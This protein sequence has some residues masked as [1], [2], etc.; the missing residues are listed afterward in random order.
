MAPEQQPAQEPAPEKK[1]RSKPRKEL[2]VVERPADFPGIETLVFAEASSLN[3]HPDNWKTHTDRQVNALDAEFDTV[4]WA[5]AYLYNRATGNMLDGH[6]RNR[7]KEVKRR[8]VVPVL[9][10][11]WTPEQEEQILLHLD[12]IGGMFETEGAKYRALMAKHRKT[13]EETVNQ[14]QEQ[15]RAAINDLNDALDTHT[16]SIDYGAPPSFLPSADLYAN[17]PAYGDEDK[18]DV[19]DLDSTSPYV[20]DSTFDLK[21]FEEIPFDAFGRGGLDIPA[22][23]PDMIA[24]PPEKLQTWVGPETPDADAYFYVYGCAAIEKVRSNRLIVAYY[25]YDHKFESVWN[26]PRKFTARMLNYQVHSVITP[27]YSC[28]NGIHKAYDIWQTFRSR[29]LGR[30]WQSVGLKVIPDL[31]V[32]NIEHDDVF[33]WRMGGL[34]VGLNCVATQM[35]QKGETDPEAYYAQKK[36]LLLKALRHLQPKSLILYHGPDLPPTFLRGIPESTRVIQVRSWMWARG[37]IL[38]GKEYLT[39]DK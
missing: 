1:P 5:G 8:G 7:T 39:D 37:E 30:Y 24:E 28:W 4:G 21:S 22:L 34:P 23:I 32:S 10:G 25:T 12:P 18:K 33:A 29:W 9:V 36:K 15:H 6:G 13:Q 14:L 16:E 27:N 17:S 38:K 20:A 31:Q 35:Q 3:E 19:V 11:S 26:D 2:K